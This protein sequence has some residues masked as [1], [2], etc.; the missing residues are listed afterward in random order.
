LD[1]RQSSRTHAHENGFQTHIE[2]TQ[3]HDDMNKRIVHKSKVAELKRQ[4]RKATMRW[5][6]WIKFNEQEWV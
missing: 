5:N 1:H 2:T 4:H 3:E 6:L